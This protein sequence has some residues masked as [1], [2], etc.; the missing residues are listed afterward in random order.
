ML[1]VKQKYHFLAEAIMPEKNKINFF[2]KC[3]VRV[4]FGFLIFGVFLSVANA[5]VADGNADIVLGQ[6]DF[7]SAYVNAL[8]SDRVYNP[9]DTIMIGSKLYIVDKKTIVFYSGIMFLF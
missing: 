3:F 9:M 6:P 4:F 7:N 8:A 5:S 1:V 2:S